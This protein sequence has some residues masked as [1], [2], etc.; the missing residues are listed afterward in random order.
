MRRATLLSFHDSRNLF[1]SHSSLRVSWGLS[2]VL[3]AIFAVQAAKGLHVYFY[4]SVKVGQLIAPELRV[5]SP[6]PVKSK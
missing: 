5:A 1:Y 2:T 4:I 3:G 6:R